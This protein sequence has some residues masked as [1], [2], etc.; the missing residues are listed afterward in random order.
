METRKMRKASFW[1]GKLYWSKDPEE[2]V[3]PFFET[4]TYLIEIRSN[5]PLLR[6]SIVLRTA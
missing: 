2:V 1:S 3:C 4:W 6:L 5:Y